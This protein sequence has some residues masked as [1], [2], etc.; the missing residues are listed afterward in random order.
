MR[1]VQPHLN[2]CVRQTHSQH[3]TYPSPLPSNI[4]LRAELRCK[5]DRAKS[6]PG[7][8]PGS[9]TS[10]VSNGVLRDMATPCSNYRLS[11]ASRITARAD[12]SPSPLVGPI[13][14]STSTTKKTKHR[15]GNS[16]KTDG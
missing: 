13:M 15:D 10:T 14:E 1:I 2:I 12:F 4:S 11:R 16:Q 6:Q 3:N 8:W 7:W 9:K 5:T